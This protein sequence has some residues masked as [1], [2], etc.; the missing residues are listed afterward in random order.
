MMTCWSLQITQPLG[1][2]PTTNHKSS[3]Q[4]RARAEALLSSTDSDLGAIKH[5]IKE[6]LRTSKQTQPFEAPEPKSLQRI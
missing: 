3:A 1:G 6:H 4:E 5:N 2:L